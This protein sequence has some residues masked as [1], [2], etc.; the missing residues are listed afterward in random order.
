MQQ[1]L[2]RRLSGN[3][4][5]PAPGHMHLRIEQEHAICERIAPPEIVEQPAVECVLAQSPLDLEHSRFV[6]RAVHERHLIV[7]VPGGQ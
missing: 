7:A 3:P 4:I 6:C 5:I 2:G 1:F